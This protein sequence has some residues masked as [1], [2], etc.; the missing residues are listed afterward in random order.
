MDD[1]AVGR[2]SVIV[3]RGL[4]RWDRAICSKLMG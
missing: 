2:S 4:T 3:N 1:A